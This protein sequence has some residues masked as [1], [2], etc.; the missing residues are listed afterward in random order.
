[1]SGAPMKYSETKLCSVY[2]SG[3][4]KGTIRDLAALQAKYGPMGYAS[5]TIKEVRDCGH[6]FHCECAPGLALFGT[7]PTKTDGESA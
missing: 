6:P 2:V 4:L 1:M 7:R 3:N 5:L